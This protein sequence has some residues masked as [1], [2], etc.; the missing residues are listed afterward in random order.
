MDKEF[1]PYFKYWGKAKKTLIRMGQTIT[2]SPTIVWMW[3]LCVMSGFTL[4]LNSL[5]N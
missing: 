1:P 4:I 5:L 2:C 3:R